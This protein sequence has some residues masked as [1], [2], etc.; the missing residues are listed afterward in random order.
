LGLSI[1]NQIV[2]DHKGYIDV[3]SQMGKGSSFFVNLPVNQDHPKRR[4][5]DSENNQGVSDTFEKRRMNKS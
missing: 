2:Q 3:E 5:A 4:K 1:S